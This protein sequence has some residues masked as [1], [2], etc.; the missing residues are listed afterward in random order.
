MSSRFGEMLLNRRRELGMSIQQVANVIKIRPQI[1]EFFE[2]GNFASMP[3]RGYAQ[4]MIASYARY[5]GLN[6][7]EVVNA[8]FDELY[9]YERGGSSAGSQFT[10]GATNPVPRSVSTSGRYLMVDPAPASRYAQRPP[11]AGYVSD[12]TS[13]HVPMP[14]AGNERRY[15]SLPEG[16][17]RRYG[18][19]PVPHRDGDGT[20]GRG[21]DLARTGSAGRTTRIR[22]VPEGE[23][24][25]S[26]YASGASRRSSADSSSQRRRSRQVPSRGRSS[27]RSQGRRG[28]APTIFDDPR[29]LIGAIV[30][31]VVIV[32][33]A[34][35]LLVRGCTAAPATQQPSDTPAVSTGSTDASAAADRTASKDDGADDDSTASASDADADSNTDTNGGAD[36]DGDTA[37][38]DTDSDAQAV[39]TKTTVTVSL[40]EGAS[41]WVEVKVDGS[42]VLSEQV[43][44]PFE[45]D[46][47]PENSIEITVD[48]PGD[49]RVTK[50][51][52]NVEWDTKTSGVGRLTISVPKS[53]DEGDTDGSADDGSGSSTEESGTSDDSYTDDSYY[54]DSEV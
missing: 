15:A 38:S 45:T 31:A 22:R 2:T 46:Y 29:V 17:P 16:A 47:T 28:P 5:L 23:G 3:P 12:S 10:E 18:D 13:G 20:Y 19:S 8:Y 40:E 30:I 49:V 48:H 21:R 26:R 36:S 6:P 44:G 25:S 1:I 27:G 9:V 35:I 39:P 51:G 32:L 14:V 11:Q 53:A 50:N 4:G 24:R 54:D 41:S 33:V 43:A 7:R 34:I 52:D 42:L 37:D